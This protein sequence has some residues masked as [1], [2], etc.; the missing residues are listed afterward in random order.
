VDAED[1]SETQAN[2]E[3][4]LVP[5]GDDSE[6]EELSRV[7]SDEKAEQKVELTDAQQAIAQEDGAA[8]DADILEMTTGKTDW[9]FD[10]TI[11]DLVAAHPKL[12]SVA[13]GNGNC[14]G[15]EGAHALQDLSELKSLAIGDN[16]GIDSK[17]FDNL[18]KLTSLTLGSTNGFGDGVYMALAKLTDLTS[19]T[20]GSKNQFGTDASCETWKGKQEAKEQDSSATE[21]FSK[22]RDLV[23]EEYK[24][25]AMAKELAYVETLFVGESNCIGVDGAKALGGLRRLKSLSIGSKNNIGV[26]GAE[27]FGTLE[28][29]TTLSI[30]N[31]NA[32]GPAGYRALQSLTKLTSLIIGDKNSFGVDHAEDVQ[33]RHEEFKAQCHK[34]HQEGE[35]GEE[36]EVEDDDVA[37]EEEEDESVVS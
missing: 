16:N 35:E 33:K 37:S 2:A 19:L 14:I 25:F 17:A 1:A 3:I 31:G 6:S 9:R 10:A 32:F 13:L 8:L 23:K 21:L 15:N 18:P 28:K 30:G 11:K 27:A 7:N 5:V 24:A 20:I 22:P 12:P 34:A 26:D 29:L 36:V 4:D